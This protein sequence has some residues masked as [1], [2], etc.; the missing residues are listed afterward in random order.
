MI[1]GHK[2]NMLVY[3]ETQVI[4]DGHSLKI[5]NHN[6][7]QQLILVEQVMHKPILTLTWVTVILQVMLQ[8]MLIQQLH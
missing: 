1:V 5:Y 2:M 4:L 6:Q 7:P 8:V 3:L